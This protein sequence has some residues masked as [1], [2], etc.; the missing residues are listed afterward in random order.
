M[1]IIYFWASIFLALYLFKGPGI[2]I[3]FIGFVV[4]L[5]FAKDIDKKFKERRV[6][7]ERCKHGIRGGKTLLHCD[8]C[9]SEYEAAQLVLEK[10]R[11]EEIRLY[12]LRRKSDNYRI[13]ELKRITK[14]RMKRLDFLYSISPREFEEA[15]GVMY[16]SLGYNVKLTPFTDDRGKDLI[17]H[18][19]SK[20][21]VV[22]CKRYAKDKKIGRPALQ[23]FFAAISEEK[24]VKGFYVT[25]SSFTKTAM[26]YAGNNNI[27]LVDGRELINIMR[28]VQ[29]GFI[30]EDTYRALCRMCGKIVIF[31]LKKNNTHEVCECGYKIELNLQ[32]LGLHLLEN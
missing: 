10:E 1:P 21:Y 19:D 7:N 24:A 22:E 3:W 16:E 31:N 8:K 28:K 2:L 15:I 27:E 14:E 12:N 26:D 9:K 4:Y 11:A 30:D 32:G 23:K 18:K 13:K 20:K 25:T 5:Y 17:I 6:R 29:T